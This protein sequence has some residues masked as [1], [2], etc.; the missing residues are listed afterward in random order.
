MYRYREWDATD[1]FLMYVDFGEVG[2]VAFLIVP[3]FTFV[4]S[5]LIG[6]IGQYFVLQVVLFS[7]FYIKKKKSKSKDAL[8]VA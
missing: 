6:V 8:W 5:I 4:L 7:L 2:S 1:L 3:V